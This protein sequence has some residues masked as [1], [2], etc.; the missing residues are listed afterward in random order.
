MFEGM[1]RVGGAGALIPSLIAVVAMGSHCDCFLLWLLHDVHV[2]EGMDMASGLE[3][4]MC[5]AGTPPHPWFWLIVD[6]CSFSA[7]SNKQ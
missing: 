5:V 3:M 1:V 6:C 7:K 4:P 2:L